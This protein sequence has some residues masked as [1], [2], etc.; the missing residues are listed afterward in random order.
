MKRKIFVIMS[1]FIL[2]ITCM[3]QYAYAD[4]GPKPSVVIDFSGLG[5]EQYFVT[6]LS[7]SDDTGPYSAVSTRQNN[8]DYQIEDEN[9]NIWKKFVAYQSESE[10]YFLQFFQ[11]CSETHTFKWGY[12]PPSKFTILIYLPEK[13]LFIESEKIYERYAFDSYYKANV[14]VSSMNVN[15]NYDFFNE[16]VSL[17]IRI[18]ITLGIEILIALL[19][20]LRQKKILQYII[21]VNIITQVMLNILLN[22]GNYMYGAMLF[23]ISY[24]WMELLIIVIESILYTRWFNNVNRHLDIKRWKAPVY[25]IVANLVSFVI[26]MLIALKLPGVF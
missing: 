21:V 20:G 6:L 25:A 11:D 10:Y 24:V 18:I 17:F 13:D 5:G 4:V 16:G 2:L 22:I 3:T 26:G 19:F 1:V 9:Y 8:E 7:E 15:E 12:Y 23:V 14:E